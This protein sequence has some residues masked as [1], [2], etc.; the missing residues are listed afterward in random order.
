LIA[1]TEIPPLKKKPTQIVSMLGLFNSSII[2][3]YL[4]SWLD[5]GGIERQARLVTVLVMQDCEL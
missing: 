3:C 1:V 4:K 5:G 2:L